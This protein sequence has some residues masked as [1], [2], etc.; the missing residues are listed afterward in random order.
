MLDRFR[1][2]AGVSPTDHFDAFISYAREP[3]AALAAQLQTSL[4]KFAKPWNKLRA[5]RVFRDDQSMAANT[6]LWSTIERGLNESSHLI[7]LVT[8]EAA[9]SEWVDKEVRWWVE[10]KS[11]GSVLLVHQAGV[12]DWDD[13]KSDFTAASAVPPSLRGAFGEEPRWVDLT[14]LDQAQLADG[15]NPTMTNAVADLSSAVR[16]VDRDTI[17]GEN[18]AE[19]RRTMRMARGAI[20]GLSSR[21]LVGGGR[22]RA[23]AT[24]LGETRGATEPGPTSR[25]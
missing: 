7:L 8:P 1:G 21:G 9:S 2:G 3:S 11:S 20:V 17:I 10:H 4:E 16:G 15:D 24:K 22:A 14:S 25:G 23:S 13:A 12:L 6:A 5:M 19:H 18:V